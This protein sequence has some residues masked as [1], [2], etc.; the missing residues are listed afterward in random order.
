M[1]ELIKKLQEVQEL[2]D[3][4]ALDIG[5]KFAVYSALKDENL[6]KPLNEKVELFQKL[7]LE[8]KDLERRIRTSE[9]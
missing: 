7:E 4:T 8:F 6:V 1:N 2:M 5:Q 9:R 3:K